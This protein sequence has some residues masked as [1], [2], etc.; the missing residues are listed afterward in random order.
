[1]WEWL[2]KPT[3]LDSTTG[4]VTLVQRFGSALNLSIYFHLLL[5]DGAYRTDGVGAR[6]DAGPRPR[7]TQAR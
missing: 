5:L 6:R 3:E 4:A 1:M 2:P 7:R